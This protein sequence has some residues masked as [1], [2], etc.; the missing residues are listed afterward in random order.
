MS[1]FRSPRPQSEPPKIDPLSSATPTSHERIPIFMIQEKDV[2]TPCDERHDVNKQISNVNLST[3]KKTGGKCIM[4]NQGMTNWKFSAFFAIALMLMAGLFTNT[5]MAGNGDGTIEVTTVPTGNLNA[6]ST[7]NSLTFTYNVPDSITDMNN[8]FF[9]LEIPR[10]DGWVVTKKSITIRDDTPIYVTDDEGVVNEDTGDADTR[11]RVEILPKSGGDVRSVKVKLVG[12]ETGGTLVIVLGNVTAAIPSSLDRLDGEDPNESYRRYKFTAS[13]LIDGTGGRMTELKAIDTDGDGISNAEAEAARAY[14]N[15]G[16][17]ADGV[18]T[19]TIRPA[20]AYE[21]EERDFSIFFDATGPMYGSTIAVTIPASLRPAAADGDSADVVLMKALR[22][23]GDHDGWEVST[24]GG[25]VTITVDSMNKNDDVRISYRDVTVSTVGGTGEFF[26][27]M[28]NT[29]GSPKL[30]DGLGA[31]ADPLNGALYPRA[32]SGTIEITSSK[33]RS[34]SVPVDTNHDFIIK[35]T[36]AT[37]FKDVYIRVEHPE[38][39]KGAAADAVDLTAV[40]HAADGT[41]S[42][43]YVSA[44]SSGTEIL[45]DSNGEYAIWGPIDFSD[46]VSKTVGRINNVNIDAVVP[47]AIPTWT[48]HVDTGLVDETVATRAAVPSPSGLVTP[49]PK[50]LR[51]ANLLGTY[52][53]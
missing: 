22:V 18:G 42:Y 45:V 17:V 34:S 39:I 23:T 37:T 7:G 33:T 25:V 53:T 2:S 51:S 36:A 35:Y 40:E 43:G 16:N 24:T 3:Q 4:G 15:V 31:E 49:A 12:W 30:V 26:T 38:V 8:G 29:T 46:G 10:T 14:V 44:T 20:V 1:T 41:E 48:V 6:A 47:D 11:A 9:L 5:A 32:G 19:V 28:T 27:V 50:A 21:G 13:S 52:Y